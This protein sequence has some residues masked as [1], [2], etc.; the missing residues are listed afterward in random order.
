M[1][2]TRNQEVDNTLKNHDKAISEIQTTLASL[3][4]QQEQSA[5]QQ[6]EILKPV[7]EKSG[8]GSGGSFSPGSGSFS[9]GDVDSRGT[10][11]MR[12]GKVEFPRFSGED[13]DAWVYR[14]EHFFTIDETPEEMKLR[15]AVIHLEG[16]AIQWHR[17]FMRTRGA[18]V[19]EISWDDYVRSIKTRFSNAM[20]E[21]PLEELASLNQTGT[22]HEL[23]TAFDALLNKVTLTETQAVSLYLKA[24]NPDIRGPVKMFKPKT[25][26]EAYGLARIQSLNNDNLEGKLKTGK[27]D[28]GGSKTNFN[29]R[30]TP[31]MNATKLPIL[32]TPNRS[33]APANKPINGPRRLTSKELEQILKN[34]S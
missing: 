23:N 14:C 34:V 3:M 9:G 5:K 30:I 13:V 26:H 25:L 4:K 15:Y 8:Q 19:S 6:Q 28:T 21:D 7:Q 32:P 16:D 29:A 27:V 12:I 1:T 33:T 24:L 10:R 22:L 18:T 20:F 11:P 31:P 2:N 17:A